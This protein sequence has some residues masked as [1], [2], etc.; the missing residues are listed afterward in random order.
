MTRRAERSREACRLVGRAGYSGARAA[1]GRTRS[2][3]AARPG[4]RARDLLVGSAAWRNGRWSCTLPT[5]ITEASVVTEGV[6]D[7]HRAADGLT[8]DTSVER[9][10]PH[11]VA[12]HHDTLRTGTV[13]GLCEVTAKRRRCPE[14]AEE[15]RR[16]RRA[17]K[18]LG[19]SQCTLRRGQ[20]ESV[21]FAS[22]AREIQP[23]QPGSIDP[24]ALVGSV[25]DNQPV[26][27]DRNGC[28]SIPSTTL[29]MAEFS[30][31]PSDRRR[32]AVIANL[33]LLG[34]CGPRSADP[35]EA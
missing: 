19:L 16:D 33:R 25:Q 30:P 18:A 17:E 7:R 20:D 2:H 12:E 3:T 29:K 21:V 32:I 11:L 27:T 13:I 1:H 26:R 35:A 4:S 24:G 8:C 34:A 28:S 14:Q 31:L 22:A 5:M 9:E 10:L 15:R 23:R 6:S